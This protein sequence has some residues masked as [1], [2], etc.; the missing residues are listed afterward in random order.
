[1]IIVDCPGC[2]AGDHTEHVEHWG[3][4]PEGVIDGEFCHC[5]GDCAERS[6]A[7]FDEFFG[8]MADIM[9]EDPLAL[10]REAQTLLDGLKSTDPATRNKAVRKVNELLA[11]DP[12]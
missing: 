6:R 4:R 5:A 2:M 9:A 3:V 12:L 11:E 8:N 1:M 10:S 7:A